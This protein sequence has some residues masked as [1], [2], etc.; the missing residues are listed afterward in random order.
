MKKFKNFRETNQTC[1]AGEYYCYT[2][3]KCKPI[4]SNYKVDNNGMLVKEDDGAAGMMGSAPTNNVGGGAIAGVGVGPAG[5]P[6]V[7]PKDNITGQGFGLRKKKKNPVMGMLKRKVQEN[8]D[9]NN[10]MLKQ[11]LDSLDKT[12]LFIDNMNAPKQSEIKMVKEEPKK[13]FKEK[14][15]IK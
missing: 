2:D 14:Y 15:N 8:T 12:D 1:K 13:S 5:E 9:N 6:G 4:P 10:V 7:Q 3:Q 11:V